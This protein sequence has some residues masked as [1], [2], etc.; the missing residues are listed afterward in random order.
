MANTVPPLSII[1]LDQ[2]DIQARLQNDPYFAGL[3][4][5]LL[6]RVGITEDDIQVALQTMQAG[7][8]AV[9][10]VVIVLMP[11]ISTDTPNAPGPRYWVR[12]ALQVIDW[13]IVRRQSPGGTG[14][15]A[16]EIADRVREIMQYFSPRNQAF[17]FDTVTP[18]PMT[19]GRV[20][21]VVRFKR[22]GADQPPPQCAAVT[23]SPNA[24]PGP[25]TLTLTASQPAGATIWYTTDGS[26]PGSTQAAP[27]GTALQYTAPFSVP[28]G[29]L[30]RAAAE[31]PS[32]G[33]QQSNYISQVQ[34]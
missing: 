20:S 14:V 19:E 5:V 3:I 15:S 9:G 4:P 8:S 2:T 12:Y 32:G 30:I 34:F 16:E 33:Y 1:E 18:V 27:V 28:S 24:G 26:Y 17:A 22:I 6:Q 11:D 23:F 29:T 21:Y 31:F 13:P 10:S 7:F 25:V